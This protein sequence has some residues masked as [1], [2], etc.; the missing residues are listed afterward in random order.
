MKNPRS[1]QR[2][3]LPAALGLAVLLL[4]AGRAPAAGTDPSLTRVRFQLRTECT[5]ASCGFVMQD[6][7]HKL[8][9]VSRVDLSPRD[10]MVTLTVDESQTPVARVAAA[11][12]G[13]EIGKRS[14]LIAEL[15]PAQPAPE[16]AALSQLDGVRRAEFDRKKQRLLLELADRPSLTTAELT[17]T[18][19][20][21]G[22]VIRLDA[23]PQTA[24]LR[25]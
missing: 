10:R 5:C 19:A 6:Q 20:R 3:S 13:T 12:A 14:A 22:I 8:R 18:L 15:A 23:T 2:R 24:S 17:A 16:A 1:F 21:A 9:G 25:H 11:L 4:G 7:L